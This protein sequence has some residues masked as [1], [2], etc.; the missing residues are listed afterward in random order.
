MPLPASQVQEL[1][2]SIGIFVTALLTDM[3]AEA[4]ITKIE[5]KFPLITISKSNIP[6]IELF[7]SKLK[8]LAEQKHTST[9]DLVE[10]KDYFTIR[11]ARK[12]FLPSNVL[13]TSNREGDKDA[14]KGSQMAFAD[15]GRKRSRSAL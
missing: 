8:H 10:E 9:F 3:L 11:T 1:Q 15:S 5:F 12:E 6:D 2:R 14:A 7:K 4:K 13:T